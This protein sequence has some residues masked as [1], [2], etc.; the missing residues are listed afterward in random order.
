[1]T[2]ELLQARSVD[3][4]TDPNY[5]NP[6]PAQNSF[7]PEPND[8]TPT[9]VNVTAVIGAMVSNGGRELGRAE[10]ISGIFAVTD[11]RC[12]FSCTEFRTGGGWRG[13]GGLA[14]PLVAMGMNA[15]SKASNVRKTRGFTLVGQVRHEWL[16]AIMSQEKRMG[17]SQTALKLTFVGPD[18]KPTVFTLS[19]YFDKRY[20]SVELGAEIARRAIA[21][22]IAHST[23]ELNEQFREFAASDQSLMLPTGNGKS[24]K[25][26]R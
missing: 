15:A 19:V 6:G 22:K 25:F 12:V 9:L 2:F 4:P 11:S 7:A 13:Y 1:M 18:E 16:A 14:G 17:A 8:G 5:P 21:Y 26:P 24:W 10:R 20:P 3:D 23:G